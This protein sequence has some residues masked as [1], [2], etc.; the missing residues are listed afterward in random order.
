[1]L[2]IYQICNNNLGSSEGKRGPKV[3]RSSSPHIPVCTSN[4][5]YLKSMFELLS[6][7]TALLFLGNQCSWHQEKKKQCRL[8][9]SS[10]R[11]RTK[12]SSE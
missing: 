10:S 8:T 7:T 12:I 11:S 9:A 1:M 3:Q 5:Y 2:F 6:R 4:E